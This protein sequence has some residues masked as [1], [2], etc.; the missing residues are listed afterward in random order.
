MVAPFLKF[1][2][3]FVFDKFLN[4]FNQEDEWMKED[5]KKWYELRKKGIKPPLK[6]KKKE[7]KSRM[8]RIEVKCFYCGRKLLRTPFRI[9]RY[10]YQF[11]DRECHRLA[12]IKF[13]IA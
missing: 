6:K 8:K 11:C 12:K 4:F 5:D 13:K 1:K 10:K 9:K 3:N 7:K 2:N